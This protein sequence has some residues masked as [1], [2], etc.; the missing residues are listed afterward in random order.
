M[1]YSVYISHSD[2][3]SRLPLYPMHIDFCSIVV[4]CSW[5]FLEIVDY[6]FLIKSVSRNVAVSCPFLDTLSTV[7]LSVDL[8]EL[9]ER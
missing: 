2:I 5:S 4:C 3:C 8:H 1:E 6:C 7:E 9:S